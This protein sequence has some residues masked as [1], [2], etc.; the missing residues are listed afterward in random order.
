MAII[1]KDPNPAGPFAGFQQKDLRCKV[2]DAPF[3]NF[4]TTN[5]NTFLGAIPAT[6]SIVSISVFCKTALTGNSVSAPT[7]LFGTASGGQQ[8]TST[9][10]SATNTTGTATSA[11]AGLV[12]FYALWNPPYT[13]GDISIW[14]IG[15]CS[16][17]NPTAGE[18]Y[19]KLDYVT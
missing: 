3:G 1:L 19:V 14:M 18:F 9:A 12:G 15:G 10:L 2:F 6:A 17:G 8:I 5:T 11:T 16:T 13:T 4:T 7:F